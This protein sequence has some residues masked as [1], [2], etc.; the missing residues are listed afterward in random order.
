MRASLWIAMLS[1]ATLF[2][3]AVAPADSTSIGSGLM[4][5]GING[6]MWPLSVDSAPIAADTG[7][8]EIVSDGRGNYTSGQMT[9]HLGDDTHI[10]GTDVCTFDLVNGTLSSN[11]DGQVCKVLARYAE[12]DC[13]RC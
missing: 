2:V 6:Y 12:V 9:E 10:A 13:S 4:R 8:M 1:A 5:C 11:A 7:T 3:A